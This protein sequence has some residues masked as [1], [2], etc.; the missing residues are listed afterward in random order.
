MPI[1]VIRW[2]FF[3]FFLECLGKDFLRRKY[4]SWDVYEK[5]SHPGRDQSIEHTKKKAHCYK[6]PKGTSNPEISG[7]NTGSPVRQRYGYEIDS[8]EEGLERYIDNQAM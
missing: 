6:R 5:K 7:E 4:L 1:G 2:I 3:F 8:A